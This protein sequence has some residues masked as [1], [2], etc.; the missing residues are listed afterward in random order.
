MHTSG[1]LR[2]EEKLPSAVDILSRSR[3]WDVFL[4]FN[5]PLLFFFPRLFLTVWGNT[6]R[7]S[8][9]VTR[10][11]NTYNPQ[12]PSARP[13]EWEARRMR[14]LVSSKRLKMQEPHPICFRIMA[15][16]STRLVLF[17]VC[18]KLYMIMKSCNAYEKQTGEINT[19]LEIFLPDARDSR[20]LARKEKA[21]SFP[22]SFPNPQNRIGC[23]S[24]MNLFVAI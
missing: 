18:F 6:Q 24:L 3:S 13:L 2:G 23:T 20:S 10:T 11:V 12:I 16:L 21:T 1:G 9:S 22:S 14:E 5:L 4:L 17:Y 15:C 7:K 19:Q 8:G